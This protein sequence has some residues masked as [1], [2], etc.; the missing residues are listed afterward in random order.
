MTEVAIPAGVQ[1]TPTGLTLPAKLKEADWE[2]VGASLAKSE[3]ALTWAIADWWAYSQ[4][5][6]TYGRTAEVAAK[7]GWKPAT[8]KQYAWVARSI[9]PKYRYPGL[10][11]SHHQEVAGLSQR[12]QDRLLYRALEDKWTVADL[13]AVVREHNGNS[14][15]AS[16][17]LDSIPTDSTEADTSDGVA[18][19]TAA[20]TKEAL[21]VAFLNKIVQ[22]WD[23]LYGAV[24][25]KDFRL[26][27]ESAESLLFSVEEADVVR[28]AVLKIISAEVGNLVKMPPLVTE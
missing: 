13:R 22:G 16:T 10:S 14:P 20:D 12:E 8:L 6:S 15:T 18:V 1:L 5:Q 4:Q 9:G 21:A 17:K 19:Y 24:T 27:V 26:T 11:F 2:A 3:G 25:H 23:Q 7:F 28:D